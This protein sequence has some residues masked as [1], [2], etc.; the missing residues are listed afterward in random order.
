MYAVV[1]D[2]DWMIIILILTLILFTTIILS[3]VPQVGFICRYTIIV[4]LLTTPVSNE[5]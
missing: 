1:N 5:W 2:N 4:L 3:S